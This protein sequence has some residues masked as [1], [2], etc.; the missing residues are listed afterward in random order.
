MKASILFIGKDLAKKL[1]L[2]LLETDQ[3]IKY[4]VDIKRSM[5]SMDIRIGRTIVLTILNFEKK[6]KKGEYNYTF[7]LYNS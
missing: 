7:T 2:K 1:D 4:Q 3:I 6:G 5:S